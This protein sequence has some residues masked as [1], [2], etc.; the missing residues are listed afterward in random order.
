M[1][2]MPIQWLMEVPVVTRCYTIGIVGVSLLESAGYVT[3]R[4]LVYTFEDVFVRGQVWRLL[5]SILYFGPFTWDSILGLYMTVRYSQNLEQS[6]YQTRHYIWCL[7]FLSTGLIIFSTLVHPLYKIG[8][9]LVDTLLYI[10]SRRNPT[11]AL[12]L[13]GLYRFDSLYLPQ[14][15][16]CLAV[17]GSQ[18][19]SMGIRLMQ[20]SS[21]VELIIGYLWGHVYLFLVDVWPKLHGSDP[22]GAR[23]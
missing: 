1:E 7:A 16:F 3:E 23:M 19:Q 12:Q 18:S 9:Y 5:T 14:V 8:T 22:T 2:H 10:Y 15:F 13:M 4:D 21:I 20:S 6:F 11:Q 17:L